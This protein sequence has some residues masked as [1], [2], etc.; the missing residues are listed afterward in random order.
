MGFFSKKKKLDY[1]LLFQEQYKSINKLTMQA[2][3]E[4]DY[5]I[6]EHLYEVI[7]EKYNEL[8]NYIDQGAHYDRK[9]FL[10]LQ[11]HALSELNSLK[12]INKSANEY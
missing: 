6:K 3:N 8:L 7:V 4:L 1:D 10:S 2:Q 9:H 12:D 11:E 5:V